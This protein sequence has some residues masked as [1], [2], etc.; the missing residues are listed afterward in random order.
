MSISRSQGVPSKSG[1]RGCSG[2]AELKRNP[3]SKRTD[4]VLVATTYS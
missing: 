4:L 3:H 2:E 1:N